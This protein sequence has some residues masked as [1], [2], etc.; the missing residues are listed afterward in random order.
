MT[1]TYLPPGTNFDPVTPP[2]ITDDNRAGLTVYNSIAEAEVAIDGDGFLAFLSVPVLTKAQ[3]E[4]ITDGTWTGND[5][6]GENVLSYI[7]DLGNFFSSS[8]LHPG[9]NQEPAIVANDYNIGKTLDEEAAE[10]HKNN[11]KI[12]RILRAGGTL[13]GI[14]YDGTAKFEPNFANITGT[15]AAAQVINHVQSR[16]NDQMWQYYFVAFPFVDY[17]GNLGEIMV[18]VSTTGEQIQNDGRVFQSDA[19][20]ST[21]VELP[22]FTQAEFDEVKGK[23]NYPLGNMF[24]S[25]LSHQ[26]HTNN[27]SL[28]SMTN[29]EGLDKNHDIL[30]QLGWIPTGAPPSTLE[31][32]ETSSAFL[33]TTYHYH[34]L[35]CP[36]TNDLATGFHACDLSRMCRKW[37]GSTSAAS[38]GMGVQCG[39]EVAAELAAAGLR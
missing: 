20:S 19:V 12:S 39:K 4:S 34:G 30:T 6:T 2:P 27:C 17:K 25:F 24:T 3:V 9:G 21:S 18:G 22:S 33:R 38:G 10:S 26:P 31:E 5:P 14:V 13:V 7:F 37:A 11:A 28:I 8:G 36:N 23:L 1:L 16:P 35:M 32:M 29:V 15:L